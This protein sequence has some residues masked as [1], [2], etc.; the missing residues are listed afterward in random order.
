MTTAEADYG[1]DPFQTS[2][3]MSKATEELTVLDTLLG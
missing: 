3:L 2:V 1:F